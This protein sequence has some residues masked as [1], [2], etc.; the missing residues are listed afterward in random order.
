[1][2]VSILALVFLFYMSSHIIYR[3]KEIK[4]YNKDENDRNYWMFTYDFKVE[5]K[6]SIFDRDSDEVI[7]N[8]NKK[9]KLIVLLYITHAAIFLYLNYFLAKILFLIL[10]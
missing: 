7:N 3:I 9:D 5:K 10:N 8:K 4:T 1:M 2:I 6:N